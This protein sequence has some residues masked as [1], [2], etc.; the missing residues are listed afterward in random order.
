MNGRS[1]EFEDTI[2]AACSIKTTGDELGW[3]SR[4]F[5]KAIITGIN[6][7]DFIR[8]LSS[9]VPIKQTD[10]QS[11]CKM[12]K[13]TSWFAQFANSQATYISELLDSSKQKMN[14][15][16]SFQEDDILL[17]MTNVAVDVS[18]K[19]IKQAIHEIF[20]PEKQL[21]RELCCL[22]NN[23]TS[24]S[25]FDLQQYVDCIR[26]LAQHS[27]YYS[28]QLFDDDM[29]T[30]ALQIIAV[31][32][33]S[34]S[35]IGTITK[36]DLMRSY[37]HE[38]TTA[39]TKIEIGFVITKFS[40][41]LCDMINVFIKKSKADDCV[42]DDAQMLE[43][44]SEV[45]TSAWIEIIHGMLLNRITRSVIFYIQ[46]KMERVFT[47]VKKRLTFWSDAYFP[48]S[49]RHSKQRKP[50]PDLSSR[51]KKYNIEIE[52]SRGP[53]APS[54]TDARMISK[55]VKRNIIIM[56]VDREAILTIST[57]G[58][59]DSIKLIYNPPC[60]ADPG[61]HFDAYVEGKVIEAPSSVSDYQDMFNSVLVAQL[62]ERPPG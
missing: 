3:M 39:A 10:R 12:T 19:T 21:H 42:C 18:E 5:S 44:T 43:A 51:L 34:K 32:L 16:V 56:D 24:K 4:C 17:H 54:K 1:M 53:H 33:I 35:G 46:A 60:S 13:E 27:A 50:L 8:D 26:N 61:G 37:A 22:Y 15:L 31:E 36:A 41:C 2:D 55:R 20:A 9:L 14:R 57:H 47:S 30:A 49:I 62:V 52:T 59:R 6:S 45:L 25:R 29:Q 38:I 48:D 58:I 40:D 23:V 7:I 11:S 28:S